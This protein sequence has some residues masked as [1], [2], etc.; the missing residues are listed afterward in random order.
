MERM[1]M[2]TMVLVSEN[3]QN[4]GDFVAKVGNYSSTMVRIWANTALITDYI[5]I[6]GYLD[7]QTGHNFSLFK[8]IRLLGL[9]L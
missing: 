5:L 3:L 4:F 8:K 6:K 7:L 9:C 2:R 1:G